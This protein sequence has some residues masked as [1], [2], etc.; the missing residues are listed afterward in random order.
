MFERF[1]IGIVVA[2]A[3]VA[4]AV[5]IGFVVFTAGN[6]F[7]GDDVA[8]GHFLAAE[9]HGV[10]QQADLVA[11]FQGIDIESVAENIAQRFAQFN[12]H[13]SLRQRALGG[14]A[15][16]Y[17][18]QGRHGLHGNFGRRSLPFAVD[19]LDGQQVK[20]TV[21]VVIEELNIGGITGGINAHAH[22]L[23][24]TQR[25][26]IFGGGTLN[27]FLRHVQAGE[28]ISQIVA[29]LYGFFRPIAALEGFIFH[30]YRR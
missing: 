17:R 29:G 18:A 10:E 28:Y 2:A 5:Q 26:G 16:H 1:A 9:V 19:F 3:F 23:T 30:K 20:L 4:G 25:F 21:V 6:Y 8:G 24:G 13:A 7:S 22:R 27:A 15:H 12:T 14:S 11:R